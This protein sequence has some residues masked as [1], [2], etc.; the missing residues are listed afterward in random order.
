MTKKKK[1]SNKQNKQVKSN[2]KLLL[3]V[4]GFFFALILGILF[5]LGAF[6]S[7]CANSISCLGD[8]SGKYDSTKKVGEFMG[9]K[10]DVPYEQIAYQPTA[11]VLGDTNS[12]KRI[13]VDLSSQ[14]LYA[15]EGNKLVYSFLI[16]SGK[17]KPTPT[18]T[19]EIWIKLRY[20][21][22]TG[23][24]P[25]IGTYYDLPNV[26]FVMFFYNNE[27]PKS[28]GYSLHGTYWHN[29]F[30]HPMSHGCVNMRIS[31]VEKLYYWA[32]PP[33]TG[34]VTY[35]TKD[36]PGTKITIYGVTPNE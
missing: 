28:M 34:S 16:S 10:I 31:D 13:L 19:F 26:P 4:V 12:P 14:R 3:I 11:N 2:L 35:S 29:N 9:R 23:G 5:V 8:L 27:I 18:G 15:Y 36:N 6:K 17:W 21:R 20:T 32:D 30:G 33:T 24:D 1:V 22:M 25:A 7:K